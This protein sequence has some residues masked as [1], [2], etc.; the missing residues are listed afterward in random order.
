[1]PSVVDRAIVSTG[2]GGPLGDAATL[3]L[4]EGGEADADADTD[5]LAPALADGARDSP[6][7]LLAH[8]ASTKATSP[9]NTFALITRRS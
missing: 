8:P 6:D 2:P 5:A 4:A 3:S 1:M 9:V 7:E